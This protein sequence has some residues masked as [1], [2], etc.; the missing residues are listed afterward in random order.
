MRVFA[1]REDALF[2]EDVAL[3]A[4]AERFG[5]PL[6]VY[7]ATALTDSYDALDSALGDTPHTLCYSIKTNMNLAVVQTLYVA[8]TR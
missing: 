7:S 3:E 5:T 6:F 1:R 4:L 8:G 2:A